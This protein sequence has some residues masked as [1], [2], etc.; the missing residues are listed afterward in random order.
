MPPFDCVTAP[1]TFRPSAASTTMPSAGA[2]TDWSKRSVT[3]VGG[4][5]TRPCSAG[6]AS[7]IVA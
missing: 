3:S 7:F 2:T 1:E 4:V 6:V 5:S